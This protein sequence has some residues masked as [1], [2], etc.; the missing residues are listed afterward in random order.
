M[1]WIDEFAIEIQEVSMA[2]D[3][4]VRHMKES[5]RAAFQEPLSHLDQIFDYRNRVL[6]VD[7]LFVARE[8][9]DEV[10]RMRRVIDRHAETC[11]S[12]IRQTPKNQVRRILGSRIE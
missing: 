11:N 9:G 1:I 7:D 5:R 3:A 12:D 6:Y 8:L 10:P 2:H 4:G